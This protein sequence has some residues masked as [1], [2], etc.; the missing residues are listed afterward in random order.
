MTARAMFRAQLDLDGAKLP[1][2]L[3]AA[4][5]DGGVHFR[6]LHAADEV[7]VKQRLVDPQTGDAVAPEDYQRAYRTE[8]GKFVVLTRE[9]QQ[10]LE[11]AASRNIEILRVLDPEQLNHQWYV[12]PY[13]LGPDG[14]STLYFALAEALAAEQLVVL[15]RWVMRKKEYSGVL[16]PQAGYLMLHTL[17][18]ADE[19]IDAKHLPHPT[20]RKLDAKELKMAEQLIG[21]L[22]DH[23]D[24][25]AYSDEYKARLLEFI[26][27][28][29]RG[30][31]V[32]LKKAKPKGEPSGSLASVLRASLS[33]ERKK[34]VA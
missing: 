5:A 28:K 15:V 31:G 16:R 17:R 34:K 33:N 3:Y 21:M 25:A 22:S 27:K 8:E 1:V 6:L 24:P 7:P 29:A 26:D 13:Y 2:K 11:P 20:G 12:R 4:V 9:D 19:V 14:S 18:H 10:A 30:E 23:F 32:R